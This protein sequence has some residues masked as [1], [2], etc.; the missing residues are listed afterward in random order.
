MTESGNGSVNFVYEA[1]VTSLAQQ[2]IGEV[3]L[4]I[5]DKATLF[6]VNPTG[7]VT[8][9]LYNNPNAS[10]T[11]LFTT[12]ANI[13]GGS[14]T[15][16]F[17]GVTSPGTYY[18]QATYNGDSNNTAA[19]TNSASDPVVVISGPGDW[20]AAEPDGAKLT[21][22]S[23]PGTVNSA[24][25]PSLSDALIGSGSATVVVPTTVTGV[26]ANNTALAAHLANST[27]VAAALAAGDE[28]AVGAGSAVVVSDLSTLATDTSLGITQTS[29]GAGLAL[30]LASNT[31][32]VAAD[33]AALAPAKLS[34]GTTEPA[35]AMAA[36][37]DMATQEAVPKQPDAGLCAG[38]HEWFNRLSD[39]G[40]A[41]RV[42]RPGG[43]NRPA[44]LHNR[45][46]VAH[47][48]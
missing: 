16:A 40:G 31:T 45:A 36:S 1:S 10:G 39:V 18:W 23:L 35:D 4:G 38:H 20:M 46:G 26:A 41:G 37:D 2:S 13:S 24:A 11:P 5:S 33:S 21:V 14:A 42:G 28:N 7:S 8:F 12:T 34:E 29:S 48:G 25:G 44:I 30:G 3:G 19:I 9:K 6:G 17:F 27:A 15:S 43:W 22:I 47:I 32:A